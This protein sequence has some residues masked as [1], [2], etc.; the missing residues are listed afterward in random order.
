MA[1]HDNVDLLVRSS[2]L[3]LKPGITAGPVHTLDQKHVVVWVT[4]GWIGSKVMVGDNGNVGE[5][6][7]SDVG[8]RA[9]NGVCLVQLGTG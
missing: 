1:L 3:D 7:E 2:A 5:E 9:Q 4:V 8:T 6:D